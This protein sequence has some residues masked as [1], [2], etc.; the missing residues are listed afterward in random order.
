LVGLVERHRVLDRFA[1]IGRGLN[2]DDR[3]FDP[4]DIDGRATTVREQNVDTFRHTKRAVSEGT[5]GESEEGKRYDF[6]DIGTFFCGFPQGF[7]ANLS[8][9]S[10]EV[11]MSEPRTQRVIGAM[12]SREETHGASGAFAQGRVF[13]GAEFFRQSNEITRLALCHFPQDHS[14]DAR[15]ND[16]GGSEEARGYGAV[17]SEVSGSDDD[18]QKGGGEESSPPWAASALPQRCQVNEAGGKGRHGGSLE[19]VAVRRQSV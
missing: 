17:M 7:G 11:Q 5:E 10:F 15:H 14:D 18:E 2:I 8:E 12:G 6:C 3:G 19:Q 13:E 9:Q 4:I 16:D 1:E